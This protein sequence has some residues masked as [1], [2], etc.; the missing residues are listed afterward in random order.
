MLA[1]AAVPLPAPRNSL[2]PTVPPA[3]ATWTPPAG[4]TSSSSRRVLSYLPPDGVQR[5]AWLHLAIPYLTNCHHAVSD[6]LTSK[7][8]LGIHR[9]IPTKVIYINLTTQAH[10]LYMASDHKP[11]SQARTRS[12]YFTCKAMSHSG[13]VFF[14]PSVTGRFSLWPNICISLYLKNQ[15]GS[16]I[17]SDKILGLE[18]KDLRGGWSP[19]WL[20]PTRAKW[21]WFTTGSHRN[22]VIPKHLVGQVLLALKKARE[23]TV[24]LSASYGLG[25]VSHSRQHKPTQSSAEPQLW[26]VCTCTASTDTL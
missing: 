7:L 5:R 20:V 25:R 11:T 13:I 12:H 9:K 19:C 16:Q 23:G 18:C 6:T 17:Q 10:P 15:V 8:A 3:T 24:G 4:P 14:S 26:S 2:I 22:M 21:S 1:P